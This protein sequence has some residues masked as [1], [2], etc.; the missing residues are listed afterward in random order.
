MNILE[1]K[2]ALEANQLISREGSN[3]TDATYFLTNENGRAY[4]FQRT[5]SARYGTI[6]SPAVFDWDDML[7]TN[8]RIVNEC[9][10]D[11]KGQLQREPVILN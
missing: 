7:A 8:W 11:N 4:L 1:A 9:N 2:A 5:V 3:H 10:T 6:E